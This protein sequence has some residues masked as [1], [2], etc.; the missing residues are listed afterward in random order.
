MRPLSGRPSRGSWVSRRAIFVL[1]LLAASGL[2]V[3]FG[4]AQVAPG[5]AFPPESGHQGVVGLAT[6]V[7]ALTTPTNDPADADARARAAH[8]AL[9][10]ERRNRGTRPVSQQLQELTTS[11]KQPSTNLQ[12]SAYAIITLQKPLPVDV[13]RDQ[14]VRG[15]FAEIDRVTLYLE[16]A[17]GYPF[18]VTGPP[19][20][21]LEGALASAMLRMADTAS[22]TPPANEVVETATSVASPGDTFASAARTA[23]KNVRTRAV[24]LGF[25][26][27]VDKFS[28]RETE[29]RALHPPA[30][31]EVE[32][33]ASLAPFKAI[34]GLI[35]ESLI[36]AL[37]AEHS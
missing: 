34:D 4:Y 18:L 23:A 5:S 37:R 27:P 35:D 22:P 16:L 15:E 9:I 26:M 10:L 19:E 31:V 8:Q 12:R 1:V 21:D 6:P 28:A 33:T 7:P 20:G 2:T 24:I 14:V 17:D 29:L 13:Y 36:A 30:A 11:I 25:A 32:P 3:T